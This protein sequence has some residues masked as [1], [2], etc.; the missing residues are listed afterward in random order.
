MANLAGV[1]ALAALGYGAHKYFNSDEEK[2]KSP[3]N[4]AARALLK[5]S[6]DGPTITPEMRANA[7]KSG[8]DITE[9]ERV[10]MSK[11]NV[12]DTED[13][14]PAVE[15][16]DSGSKTSASTA[17]SKPTLRSSKKPNVYDVEDAQ[18]PQSFRSIDPRNSAE[19]AEA[20]GRSTRGPA[21][22]DQKPASSYSRPMA[23]RAGTVND[24]PTSGYPSVTGGE[25]VDSTELGRNIS[26]TMAAMGPGKL[27]G[28]GAIGNEM[29]M[30]R[31]AAQATKG[32]KTAKSANVAE[33][34]REAVTN[35][36][37]W[38]M[39]PKNSSMTRRALNE[40]D[41]TGG[42]IG[43]RKGGAVKKMASG[44]M[45]SKPSSASKRGDGIAQKGKTNCKMR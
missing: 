45:T 7:I 12:Y 5:G 38:A 21:L 30:A 14:R 18:K 6:E 15:M 3:T 1:A 13:A 39:G 27:S 26:N 4:A 37:E 41:T 9:G 8:N 31:Q 28:L 19:A 24:I 23:S 20:Y 2:K 17:K 16:R 29:R 35:P 32:A 36:L 10:A 44:G 11:P 33:E 34:G 43:Y 25:R 42:A 22:A 40:T